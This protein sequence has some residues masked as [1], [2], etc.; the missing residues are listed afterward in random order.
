MNKRKVGRYFALAFIPM[1]IVFCM[2][3]FWFYST[4]ILAYGFLLGGSVFFWLVVAVLFFPGAEV[5]IP[6]DK[7]GQPASNWYMKASKRDKIVWIVALI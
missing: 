4:E 1:G 6:I 3:A 2:A 5:A 7:S